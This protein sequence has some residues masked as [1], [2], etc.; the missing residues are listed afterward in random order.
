[1]LNVHEI[2]EEKEELKFH[3]FVWFAPKKKI[4]S[5]GSKI[6][7]NSSYFFRFFATYLFIFM[8]QSNDPVS[9]AT[10]SEN[11][12]PRQADK[13]NETVATQQPATE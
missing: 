8:W 12:E 9:R 10:Q 2:D 11:H 7:I 1:M 4:F 6:L 13:V 3:N 5:D